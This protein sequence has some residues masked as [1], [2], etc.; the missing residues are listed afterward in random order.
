[1]VVKLTNE[2]SILDDMEELADDEKAIMMEVIQE[3]IK[4]LEV[5][6]DPEKLIGKTIDL[7]DDNDYMTIRKIY[8][9][10]DKI[11]KLILD[12]DVQKLRELEA[13]NNG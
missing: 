13:I 11:R 2:R 1:M 5:V 9:D 3:D 6:A 7:W 8:G 10:S 4:A 12:R